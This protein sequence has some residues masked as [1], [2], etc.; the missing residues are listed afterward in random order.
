MT[1]L[2]KILP[3]WQKFRVFDNILRVYSVFHKILNLLGQLFMLLGKYLLLQIAKYCKINKFHHL[4][5]LRVTR[6]ATGLCR[7]T[8]MV[9]HHF[10]CFTKK[11]ADDR[12]TKKAFAYTIIS[13]QRHKKSVQKIFVI[14]AEK[15][16]IF[17]KRFEPLHFAAQMTS[18]VLLLLLVSFEPIAV[19][20]CFI[21]YR[22]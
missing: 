8:S 3:L 5:T 6:H 22:Q 14:Y 20:K 4:V 11:W 12:V 19:K 18:F 10:V 16:N 2:D 9:Y 21:N 17:F 15:E 1:R 7:D 13:L